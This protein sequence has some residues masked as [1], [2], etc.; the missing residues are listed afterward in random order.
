MVLII[1]FIA[2]K[3]KLLFAD[4]EMEKNPAAMS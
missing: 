4:D 3:S 2:D 1:K